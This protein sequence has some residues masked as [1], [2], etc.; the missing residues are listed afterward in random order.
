MGHNINETGLH[1]REYRGVNEKNKYE[2]YNSRNFP[3]VVSIQPHSLQVQHNQSKMKNHAKAHPN[4]ISEN[5]QQSIFK[6][7][8]E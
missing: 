3:D 6:A 7:A 2:T 5:H 8:K 1:K 4:Q